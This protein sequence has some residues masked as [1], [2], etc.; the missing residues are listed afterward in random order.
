MRLKAIDLSGAIKKNL[1]T[2]EVERTFNLLEKERFEKNNLARKVEKLEKDVEG[3]IVC[4]KE[5]EAKITNL[6]LNLK[7][8]KKTHFDQNEIIKFQ[9]KELKTKQLETERKLRLIKT[10]ADHVKL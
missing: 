5:K 2:E 8:T 3:Y 1:K 4:I 7:N 6:L 10:E 9:L